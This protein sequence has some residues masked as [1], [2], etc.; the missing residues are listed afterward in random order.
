[1]TKVKKHKGSNPL[2]L[3]LSDDE[4]KRF[5]RIQRALSKDLGSIVTKKAT[6]IYLI[7]NYS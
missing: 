2:Y 7:K 5:D 3:V 1:M 4:M 6:L